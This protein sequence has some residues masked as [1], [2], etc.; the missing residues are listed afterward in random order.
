VESLLH[1]LAI[2][3]CKQQL[4]NI[5]AAEA[6]TEIERNRVADD[7]GRKAVML[8]AMSGWCVLVMS[9]AHQAGARQV[10]Q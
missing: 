5:S 6:E 9:I 2:A 7:L 1:L 10:V 4:L 8:V 3:A